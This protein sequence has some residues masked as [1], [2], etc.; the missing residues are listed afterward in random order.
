MKNSNQI[1]VGVVMLIIF[2]AGIFLVFDYRK[3]KDQSILGS[4]GFKS[5]LPD[6]DATTS[7]KGT[8]AVIPDS[9]V[10]SA[11]AKAYTNIAENGT[12]AP[13]SELTNPSPDD[14]VTFNPHWLGKWKSGTNDTIIERYSGKI[15][16]KDK[17]IEII[18]ANKKWKMYIV[19]YYGDTCYFPVDLISEEGQWLDN[20]SNFFGKR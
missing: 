20:I 13:L 19:K 5:S 11:A 7:S 17:P 9:G 3:N 14:V 6:A 1:T 12:I 8:S 10:N 2:T 16:K 15:Y 18:G 4:L